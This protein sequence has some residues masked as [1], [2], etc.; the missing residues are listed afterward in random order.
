MGH[1]NKGDDTMRTH[2]RLPGIKGFTLVEIL[3]ILVIVGILATI[4]IPSYQNFIEDGKARICE[5]NL[6]A[7]KSAFDVYMS[8][9]NVVPGDLGQIPAADIEKALARYRRDATWQE[10]Y[11]RFLDERRESSY[12]FASIM[13]E[14]AKG[15][16]QMLFCPSDTRRNST[17]FSA[18]LASYGMN[19]E[20]SSMS[21]DKYANL[22]VST[23]VIADCE[24]ASFTSNTTMTPRH[25]YFQGIAPKKYANFVTVGG[26]VQSNNP[27]IITIE[28]TNKIEEVVT[29]S[30]TLKAA[31]RTEPP[32]S[33][34]LLQLYADFMRRL[35]ALRMQLKQH[36]RRR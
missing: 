14:L 4:G 33:S 32:Q 36:H 6:F 7:L 11:V 18:D 10:K 21:Q 13:Q 29:A 3:V 30:A 26:W 20:L 34:Y 24:D 16:L 23:P 19:Q 22:S 25:K 27:V 15:N 5:T 9:H 2:Q 28:D 31:E 17:T 35:E 1:E 12:A 8:E